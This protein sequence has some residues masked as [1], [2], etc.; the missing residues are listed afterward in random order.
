MIK[1]AQTGI[2]CLHACTRF[3]NWE[4]FMGFKK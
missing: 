3:K 4:E 2:K 1:K